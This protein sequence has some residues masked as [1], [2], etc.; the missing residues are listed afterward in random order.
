[1]AKLYLVRH[2]EPDALWGAHPDPGL[3]ELGQTQAQSV[4][5]YLLGLSAKALLTSPLARCRE[6]AVPCEAAY[7]FT[8]TIEKAV[9]E[10]PVPDAVTDHRTWLGAVMSGHWE[11]AHV[12]EDLRAWRDNVARTLVG[13]CQDTIVFSHFVAI[14]AAVS[15][16]MGSTNVCVFK[17]GHASVTILDNDGGTL[18]VLQLGQ[19]SAIRLA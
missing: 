6:T 2:A 12:G 10:V 9:A 8:A 18:R 3:S 7:G 14:N 16:A 13:Q 5:I 19:E 11:E 4:S 15:V 17:P 1:M